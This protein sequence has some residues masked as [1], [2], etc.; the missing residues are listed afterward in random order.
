MPWGAAIGIVRWLCGAPGFE[1]IMVIEGSVPEEFWDCIII[2]LVLKN[3]CYYYGL[4]N[5]FWLSLLKSIKSSFLAELRAG[6]LKSLTF[7]VWNWAVA[8]LEC[9][10]FSELRPIRP[11]LSLSSWL[12]SKFYSCILR[13]SCW[14]AMT[15]CC[16]CED[17][18]DF[19]AFA[20][21]RLAGGLVANLKSFFD[22]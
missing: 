6:L 22:C 20:F 2:E 18:F 3:W 16:Y 4:I 17:F 10:P 1:S 7:N 15:S 12:A 9:V 8:F 19:D 21:L 13:R 11:S 14:D 5:K